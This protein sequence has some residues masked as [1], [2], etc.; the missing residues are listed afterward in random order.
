MIRCYIFKDIIPAF[1]G[2]VGEGPFSYSLKQER[3]FIVAI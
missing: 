2:A 1:R 3:R